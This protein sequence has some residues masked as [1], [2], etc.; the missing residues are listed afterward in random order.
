M[1]VGGVHGDLC[2]TYVVGSVDKQALRLIESCQLCLDAAINIC[3]P[4]TRFSWIG[5]MIR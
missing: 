4:G 3:K 1:Y 5:N 2:E